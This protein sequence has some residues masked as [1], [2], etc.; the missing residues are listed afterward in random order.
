MPYSS[1]S[2]IYLFY[3]K[4]RLTNPCVHTL[5][6]VRSLYHNRPS[7]DLLFFSARIIL[8]PSMYIVSKGKQ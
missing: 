3:T 4:L 7:L 8:D 6:T 5:R 1:M 2:L